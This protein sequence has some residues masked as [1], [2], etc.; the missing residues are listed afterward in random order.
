MEV[1]NVTMTTLTVSWI[2]PEHPNGIIIN[3]ELAYYLQHS[4]DGMYINGTNLYTISE[5]SH[6]YLSCVVL[7]NYK[8]V[9]DGYSIKIYKKNCPLAN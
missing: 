5:R 3:Y 8:L 1:N 4:H 2:P 6:N 7:E 9:I